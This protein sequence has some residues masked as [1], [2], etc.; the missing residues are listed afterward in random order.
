VNADPGAAVV[1]TRDTDSIEPFGVV[2]ALSDGTLTPDDWRRRCT[3]FGIS[4]LPLA[5]P[6]WPPESENALGKEPAIL[7][8][9]PPGQPK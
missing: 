3:E 5:D 9:D 8:P 7:V 1:C 2:T 6:S 4:D